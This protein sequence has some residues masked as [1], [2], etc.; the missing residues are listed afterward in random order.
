MVSNAGVAL[1]A[2]AQRLFMAQGLFAERSLFPA[3]D[4]GHRLLATDIDVLVSEYSSGFHLTRR[5]AECKSGRNVSILDRVLWLSGV[6]TMLG[7]DAS[8]FIVPAFDEGAGDFAKSLNVD[9]MTIK[10][11]ETWETA[12]QIPTDQWPNRSEFKLLDPIRVASLDLGKGIDASELDKSIRSAVQFVE[13]DSWRVFGYGR[14]NQL[15]RVLKDLSDISVDATPGDGKDDRIRYATSVLLVRLSQYLL[16]VCH[17]VSCVPVSD[18]HSYLRNRLT[19]GDQDP[20]RARGLVQRTVDWMSEAMKH[21]GIAIPP[22]V[23]L[24]RL[25][26]PPAYCEGMIAL[27]EKIL[28]S[29]NEARY[30]PVAMETDQF[31]KEHDVESFPRLR[32]AWQAGRGFAALVRGFTVSSLGIDASLL[33]PLWKDIS[34][35]RTV[36][37]GIKRSARRSPGQAKLKLEES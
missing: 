35:Q 15:L 24:N 13:I 23:D 27:T 4:V 11:L 36:N 19:F 14:L 5:H 26:Q 34:V 29:P 3:A 22:E 16:A 20:D 21:R 37:H 28:A 18:V 1:E 12:L 17:D 6:R 32:L 8:Y 9:V 30:L 7:A 25:L 10:Q 31:G 33:T 2:R